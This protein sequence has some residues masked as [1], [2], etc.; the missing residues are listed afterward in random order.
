[1]AKEEE[2]LEGMIDRL[3]EIGRINGNGI[4]ADKSKLMEIKKRR[5]F[6]NQRAKQELESVGKFRKLKILLHQVRS[7]TFK[8]SDVKSAVNWAIWVWVEE[9]AGNILH[10][11]HYPSRI[12][13]M[14][15]KKNKKLI[16]RESFEISILISIRPRKAN[17]PRLLF[18]IALEESAY[19]RKTVGKRKPDFWRRKIE[20]I[21]DLI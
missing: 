21:D 5:I 14:D 17:K 12:G 4:S 1:M 20:L 2:T 3:V 9:E 13:N 10:L 11:K 6:T 19:I 15:I 8:A 7:R 16:T 18:N